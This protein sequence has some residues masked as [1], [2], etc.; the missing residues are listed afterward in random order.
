M[1]L[2][3]PSVSSNAGLTGVH[4]PLIVANGCAGCDTRHEDHT[5]VVTRDG[6]GSHNRQ[7]PEIALYVDRDFGQ[8]DRPIHE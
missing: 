3:H 2:A 8:I 6:S 5:N 1:C 7:L 4:T